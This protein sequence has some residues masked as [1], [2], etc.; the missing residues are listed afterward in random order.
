[1]LVAEPRNLPITPAGTLAL[2][3]RGNVLRITGIVHGLTPGLHGIHVHEFGK[4][5]DGCLEAGDHYNP[6]GMNHGAPSAKN[7]HVGDLGNIIAG[8]VDLAKAPNS[9]T[10]TSSKKPSEYSDTELF[11]KQ[12]F[13]APSVTL[14]RSD[15]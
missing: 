6:T 3:Q 4:L 10:F 9:L 8:D 5:G 15:D 1:M 7:R 2:I 11:R 13:L 12:N 14:S